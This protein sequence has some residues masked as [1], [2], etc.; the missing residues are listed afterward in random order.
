MED[1]PDKKQVVHQPGR[2]GTKTQ[3]RALQRARQ[4]AIAGDPV[5]YLEAVYESHALDGLKRRLEHQWGSVDP[6]EVDRLLGDVVD[7]LYDALHQGKH[8]TSMV[9]WLFKAAT[10]QLYDY[11]KE[12]EL[13]GLVGGQEIDQLAEGVDGVLVRPVGSELNHGGLDRDEARK[14]AIT[15]ARALLPQLG[16]VNVQRVMGLI[17]DALERGE[18]D[19]SN[20]EIEN[21]LGLQP[22][23]VRVC[24]YRGFVRLGRLMAEKGWSI[25]LLEIITGIHDGEEGVGNGGDPDSED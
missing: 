2:V 23:T 21:A 22:G 24:R 3:E 13:E 15:I 5:G 16:Q 10:K 7:A 8:I 4:A 20:E 9:G 12:R 19:F 1:I 17:L 14:T 6:N 18:V 11:V 25:R